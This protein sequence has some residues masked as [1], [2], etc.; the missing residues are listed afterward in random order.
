MSGPN[1]PANSD[2]YRAWDGADGQFWADNAD[3]F[4]D[5]M[6]RYL[7]PLLAGAALHPAER[8]LDIG[9]GNGVTTIEAARRTSPG[10]A[11]GLDLSTAMLAV[12]RRRA[13]EQRV[14]NTEFVQ[15]DAQVYPFEPGGFDVVISRFG[16]MFFADPGAAFANIGRAV[17]P[18]GR[19]AWIVWQ[20]AAVNP[21]MQVIGRSLAAGRELPT[22]PPDAP[23]PFALADPDRMQALLGGAGFERVTVTPAVHLMGFGRDIESA[24]H[25][26][27][28][29][30]GAR[31]L[32]KDLDGP[33][34]AEALATLRTALAAHLTPEGVLLDSAAWLVR[35]V[36]T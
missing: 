1:D 15:A 31:A 34:R 21:W 6:S 17:R 7:E 35:A 23:S 25:F 29:L 36:R 20:A 26:A 28:G 33:A 27:A 12:A 22:P 18:G 14:L 30:P 16:V 24:F 19:L 2:A 4:D 32:L 11:M 10:R 9:C 8:V 13:V 5:G 3:A